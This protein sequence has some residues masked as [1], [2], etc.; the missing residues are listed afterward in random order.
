MLVYGNLINLMGQQ[1]TCLYKWLLLIQKL[2]CSF[3]AGTMAMGAINVVRGSRSSTEELLQIYNHSERLARLEFP[4]EET[5]GS[6]FFFFEMKV[7][8][9]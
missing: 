7:I 8:R 4:K 9:Y 2:H 1:F 5:S 6:A 3:N